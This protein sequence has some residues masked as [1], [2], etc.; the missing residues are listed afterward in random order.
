MSIYR[1]IILLFI[2]PFL[3]VSAHE[4]RSTSALFV[5]LSDAMTHL[6]DNDPQAAQ[7]Q[8]D[9]LTQAFLAQE[10]AHSE[11]GKLVQ[12]ALKQAQQTPSL[13]Q[14]NH[15]AKALY[16]FEKEQNPVDYTKQR[17]RFKGRVMPAYQHLANAT[18]TQDLAA[19][20]ASYAQFNRIWTRNEQVVRE[21]SLGHYGQIETAMAFFRIA[22]LASPP[23]TAA[24][25]AQL[26]KLNQALMDFNQG[27]TAEVVSHQASLAQGIA[28]LEQAHQAQNQEAFAAP[29]LQFIENWPAFE[30]EVRNKNSQLYHKIESQL[31]ILLAQNTPSPEQLEPLL[32]ALKALN[33][34]AAYSAFDAML[35]LLREGV[36][37]LL[38]IMALVLA[39]NAAGQT[40][41]RRYVYA[42]AFV[43]LFA[44]VVAA[45]ALQA[46]FP[47]TSAGKN[48]EVIEGIVGLIAVGFMLFIGAW[49]H[50][51]S[52][53]AGWQR[54]INTRLNQAIA[55]GSLTSLGLLSF[56]VVFREGAETLLFYTSILP[57]IQ[58]S[59]FFIGIALALVLLGIIAILMRLSARRL[60]MYQLFSLMTWLIYA[61]GFKM[62]GVSIHILQLSQILPYHHSA[63]L[64]NLPM[65]GLYPSWQSLAAQIL[66]LAF[67]PLSLRI[68]RA[69]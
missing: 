56:L 4:T 37:A 31:P 23:D 49:L 54:F 19:I 22:M 3:S 52:S 38:I 21:T 60:A 33:P 11:A 42:G 39:L 67:I 66:Y 40:Q 44:S 5:T 47:A 17:L 46:L 15:V 50:N 45:F 7:H 30:G 58:Y 16:A 26:N 68:Q 29:I 12:T 1:L 8:L 64:P 6:K 28:L 24:M 34:N 13:A 48:R 14:L 43:G 18:Q 2:L 51:K 20:Q 63:W 62:L 65:L 53:L 57:R 69:R 36:E 41:G 55:K 32:D 59:D 25:N 10:N 27:N 9:A 61:L 35:I